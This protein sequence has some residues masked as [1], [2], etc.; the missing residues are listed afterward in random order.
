LRRSADYI[1]KD[2]KRGFCS[3]NDPEYFSFCYL[4][5]DESWEDEDC[6]NDIDVI[7]VTGEPDASDHGRSEILLA[8]RIYIKQ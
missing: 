6:N 4:F 2:E 8:C 5:L 7:V 3:L 1:Y